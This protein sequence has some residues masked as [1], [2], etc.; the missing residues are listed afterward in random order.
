MFLLLYL[1]HVLAVRSRHLINP[2]AAL[3][4]L[5]DLQTEFPSS[6][7]H[8]DGDV[9]LLLNDLNT[10]CTC[11]DLG[12]VCN[13]CSVFQMVLKFSGV[14]GDRPSWRFSCFL[15]FLDE[16]ISVPCPPSNA[17]ICTLNSLLKS[18][19]SLEQHLRNH[20]NKLSF[21]NLDPE[22]LYPWRPDRSYLLLI[23][24]F[25]FPDCLWR[26]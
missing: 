13:M 24:P 12:C 17:S 23:Q 21:N 9:D 20:L 22:S 4:F 11:R 8:Q 15:R 16:D 26:N 25:T 3:Q 19:S 14:L 6:E 18:P 1:A 5:A 10:G 7:F 2:K